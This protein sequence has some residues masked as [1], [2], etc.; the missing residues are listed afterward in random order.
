[1]FDTISRRNRIVVSDIKMQGAWF[2]IFD[3]YLLLERFCAPEHGL[4][5]KI[6]LITIS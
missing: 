6:K 5:K 1:M 2:K 4:Q 3:D